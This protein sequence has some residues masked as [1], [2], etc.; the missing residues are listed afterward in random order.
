[1]AEWQTR[2]LQVPVSFGTWGF[3]SPFAHN[4]RPSGRLKPQYAH[5]TD[6]E[7]AATMAIRFRPLRILL[8][9]ACG[10]LFVVAPIATAGPAVACVSG[11][12]SDPFTGQ[13]SGGGGGYPSVNGVPCIPG[14]HMGT[15]MGFLQNMPRPG[16]TLGP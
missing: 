8:A 14:Q 5:V 13:C 7:S 9:T 1:V 15:C 4:Q 12:Y 16:A 2:W 10:A 11:Q 3:K 6:D